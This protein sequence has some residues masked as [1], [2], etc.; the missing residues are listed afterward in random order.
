MSW[1]PRSKLPHHMLVGRLSLRWSSPGLT[2]FLDRPSQCGYFCTT[3]T[4]GRLIHGVRFS[5][6]Q[7]YMHGGF[8]AESGFDPGTLRLRSQDHTTIPLKKYFIAYHKK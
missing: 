2:P 3:P 8:L 4:G 5:V 7:A 6:L 1:H